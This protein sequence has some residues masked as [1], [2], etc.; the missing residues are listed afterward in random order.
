M[1][2]QF[3]RSLN[4]L[5]RGLDVSS[6]RAQVIANNIANIDTP[7]FKSSSVPFSQVLSRVQG[8]G[9][10]F[11]GRRTRAKHFDIRSGEEGDG[12]MHDNIQTLHRYDQNNVD[13]EYEMNELARNTLYYNALAQKLT[14]QYG[15]LRLAISEGR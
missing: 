1:A 15:R 6:V 10:G 11:V 9:G 5:Q 3:V 14:S 13:I 2:D 7:G 12:V 8:E 4:A